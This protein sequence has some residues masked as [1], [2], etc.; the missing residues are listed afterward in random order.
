MEE[1]LGVGE[2][3][4]VVIDREVVAEWYGGMLKTLCIINCTV[5]YIMRKHFLLACFLV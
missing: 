5:L 4:Y 1:I 2:L 3:M